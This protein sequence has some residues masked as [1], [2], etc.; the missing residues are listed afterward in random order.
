MFRIKVVNT[1]NQ[2]THFMLI[3]FFF[4][5]ICFYDATWENTGEPDRLQ[6]TIWYMRIACWLPKARIQTCVQNT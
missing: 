4:P 2:N 3:T 6:M 1:V 5:K